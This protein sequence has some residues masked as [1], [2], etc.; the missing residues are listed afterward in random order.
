MTTNNIESKWERLVNFM[1]NK[2]S[3]GVD[4]MDLQSILFVIGIQE[5][6]KGYK[7]FSKEEKMDLLHI[8][9]CKLLSKYG[10]YEFDKKDE[11]GWPHYNINKKMPPLSPKK[12]A[13]LMKEAIIAYFE[14]ANVEF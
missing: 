14:E 12:Q 13:E 1:T 4:K 3:D 11:E 2:F 8:A 5:L 9:I 7:E 6:G 10:Y